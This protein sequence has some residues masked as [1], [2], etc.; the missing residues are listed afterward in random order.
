MCC[1]RKKAKIMGKNKAC[2]K[3]CKSS[4]SWEKGR[5]SKACENSTLLFFVI[6]FFKNFF[7]KDV[8]LL[9]RQKTLSKKIQANVREIKSLI[10]K[11]RLKKKVS[12]SM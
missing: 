8:L 10:V 4:K 1:S 12:N 9:Q 6:A 5:K 3:R 2:E 11:W 7:G